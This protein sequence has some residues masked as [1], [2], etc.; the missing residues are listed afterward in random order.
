MGSPAP[1]ILFLGILG[2]E[3]TTM[4]AALRKFEEKTDQFKELI[5]YVSQKCANDQS[6]DS[7]KLSKVLFF[8]DFLMYALSGEP[9]T[10]TEYIKMEYGPAP[11]HIREL[12]EQMEK[13]KSLG[14]QNLPLRKWRRPVN[15]REPNLKGFTAAE[16][17]LVDAVIDAVK[18][19]DGKDVSE[20]THD[21]MCWKMTPSL[22]QTIPYETVFLSHEEPT[23]ADIERGRAVARELDLVEQ[24]S[25]A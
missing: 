3:V 18:G 9:I 22:G 17:S 5:L 25:V 10:G 15:L 20:L 13:E 8:S 23:P 7:L 14:L 1:A 21:W 11:R 19:T 24:H 12:K 6:F 16:I 2:T 4:S